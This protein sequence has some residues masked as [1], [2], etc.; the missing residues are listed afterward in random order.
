MITLLKVAQIY[1]PNKYVFLK[2][3]ARNQACRTQHC[4]LPL[5]VTMGFG[6]GRHSLFF[7]VRFTS[8]CFVHSV[9]GVPTVLEFGIV[10][11]DISIA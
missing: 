10:N 6:I 3:T 5:M 8:T 11:Q 7:V 9:Y 1:K 4:L 2:M